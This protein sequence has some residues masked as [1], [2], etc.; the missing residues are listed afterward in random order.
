V[1]DLQES[2][3]GGWALGW[4]LREALSDEVSQRHLIGDW[5]WV[6]H[7]WRV[8]PQ[9]KSCLAKHP[10]VARGG[11]LLLHH[12]RAGVVHRAPPTQLVDRGETMVFLGIARIAEIR[13]Q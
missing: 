5:G 7:R 4:V 10:H 12:V 13:K 11:D 1:V 8:G 9:V 2:L 6:Q 3:P